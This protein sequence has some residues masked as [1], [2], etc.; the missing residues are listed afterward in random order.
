MLTVFA[1]KNNEGAENAKGKGRGQALEQLSSHFALE[2][3]EKGTA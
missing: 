3:Y 2:E 1:D